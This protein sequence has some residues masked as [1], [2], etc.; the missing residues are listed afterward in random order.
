MWD[1]PNVTHMPAE[2]MFDFPLSKTR[3]KVLQGK[4]HRQPTKEV[5]IEWE[6]SPPGG[7]YGE[8]PSKQVPGETSCTVDHL[9]EIVAE[10]SNLYWSE[11]FSDVELVI[12]E[13][14]RLKAHRVVLALSSDVFRQMF[15][16]GCWR[17]GGQEEVALTEEESC[18]EHMDAFLQY[19]YTGAM[20]IHSGNLFPLLILTDKYNVRALRQSCEQFALQSVC[21]GPVRR[22]LAWWRTAEQIGFQE[23]EEACR[24]YVAL[25]GAVLASSSDWLSLELERLLILLQSDDLQV[26]NEFQLFHAVKRWLLHKEAKEE[27]VQEGVL[28]H[29]RFPLMSPLEVYNACYVGMLP[30]PVRDAFLAESILIYKVN[31]LPIEAIGL[32][33]DIQAPRFTMRMYTSADFGCSRK[34]EGFNTAQSPS[35]DFTTKL[36]QSKIS[37][38]I[39]SQFHQNQHFGSQSTAKPQHPTQYWMCRIDECNLNNENHEHQLCVLMYRNVA[40]TW[41]AC[42]YETYSIPHKQEM[43][44]VAL[45]EKFEKNKCVHKNTAF[46]H[47]IGKIRWVKFT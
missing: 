35:I 11:D 24:R 10:F 41:L 20:S 46:V 4:R 28:E 22:A 25:N 9:D 33:H 16:R 13:T 36:F 47:F 39:R 7:Q 29:V 30:T 26:E 44:L 14:H 1:E 42:D 45:H 15:S 34:I 31:S 5:W 37:W 18:V 32:Y 3:A 19:F 38:K 23:L 40:D 27:D 8:P 17:E 12:N 6:P 43:P 2:L 21:A